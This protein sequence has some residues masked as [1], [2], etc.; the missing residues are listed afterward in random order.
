MMDLRVI[1]LAAAL[2]SAASWAVGSILFK[3]IGEKLSPL[4]MT[5]AKG[6][7]SVILLALVLVFAGYGTVEVK[8]L[9]LLILFC[10]S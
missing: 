2:G 3:Q 1:G 4:A 5:L 7:I 10:C 6:T 8:S 9:L